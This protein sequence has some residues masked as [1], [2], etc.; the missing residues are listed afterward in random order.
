MSVRIRSHACRN[1]VRAGQPACSYSWRTPAEA[2]A[3]SY[4]EAARLVPVADRGGQRVQRVSVRD[5]LVRAVSVVEL[6]ELAEGMQQVPLVPDQRPV[7]Q[8]AAA[9]LYPPF[10]D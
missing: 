6:F 1:L 2:V 3:S 4:V 5:A 7:H 8:F 10:H 9:G